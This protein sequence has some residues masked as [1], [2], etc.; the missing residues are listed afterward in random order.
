[1]AAADQGNE[2]L[3]MV[4]DVLESPDAEARSEFFRHFRSHSEEFASHAAEALRQWTN[5]SDV[6][7]D[8]SRAGYVAMV[9]FTALNLNLSSFKLFMSGHTVAAGS[10]F[11][12]VL[13]AI[14]MA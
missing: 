11:R 2:I 7:P 10:Q 5:F 1:M 6:V 3:V 14:A 8:N 4:K 13:E 12:Q 9:L